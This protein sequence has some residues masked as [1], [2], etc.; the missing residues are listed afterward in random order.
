MPTDDPPYQLLCQTVPKDEHG[1]EALLAQEATARAQ[2]FRGSVLRGSKKH[3]Y[4]FSMRHSLV[5]FFQVLPSTD[6]PHRFAPVLR[7]ASQEQVRTSA[8]RWHL[9]LC[10][11]RG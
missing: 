11:V 5:M 3:T 1:P 10:E 7:Y 2:R 9:L 6:Q 4:F 8:L